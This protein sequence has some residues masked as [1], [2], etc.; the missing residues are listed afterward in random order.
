AER[1]SGRHDA[2]SCHSRGARVFHDA[3]AVC[4]AKS[5]GTRC[6]PAL[7]HGVIHIAP[8]RGFLVENV[9]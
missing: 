6:I 8:L 9:F 5:R 4:R 3:P 1:S 2:P 7:T